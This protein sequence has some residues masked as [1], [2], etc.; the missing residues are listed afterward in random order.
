MAIEKNSPVSSEYSQATDDACSTAFRT[1]PGAKSYT[2]MH[3]PVS[4]EDELEEE[5]EDII[6]RQQV[7]TQIPII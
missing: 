5:L 1:G 2:G 4:G 3:T 7:S 6:K